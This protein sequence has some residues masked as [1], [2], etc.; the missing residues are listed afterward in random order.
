[1]K[2]TGNKWVGGA[3]MAVFAPACI[4]L[5]GW[6]GTAMFTFVVGMIIYYKGEG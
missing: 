5:N 1:M 2:S 6:Y 3:L 4:I